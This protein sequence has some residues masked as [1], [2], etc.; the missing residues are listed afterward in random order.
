M[1]E[2]ERDD[3]SGSDGSGDERGRMA[4]PSFT[5]GFAG[6]GMDVEVVPSPR[7]RKSRD[8]SVGVITRTRT[9]K[10]PVK[11]L[12]S[13]P[14]ETMKPKGRRATPTA[15]RRLTPVVKSTA[16]TSPRKAAVTPKP[17]TTPRWKRA[18]LVK[19]K[20][21]AAEVDEEDDGEK[22]EV[23]PFLLFVLRRGRLDGWTGVS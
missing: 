18:S 15:P 8:R 1:V 6:E 9:T 21:T 11:G 4:P 20:A 14:S 2:A 13:S 5:L 12:D 3:G 17:A 10:V 22:H 7:Q 19:A 16:G 23:R